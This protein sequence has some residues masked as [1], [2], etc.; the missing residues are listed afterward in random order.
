MIP[1]KNNNPI[2]KRKIIT[3][4]KSIRRFGSLLKTQ[5]YQRYTPYLPDERNP[6]VI[7]AVTHSEIKDI[8]RDRYFVAVLDSQ[9]GTHR[10]TSGGDLDRKTFVLI[11]RADQLTKDL[12]SLRFDVREYLRG[13]GGGGG[14][15]T[16]SNIFYAPIDEDK[17]SDCIV[18][19]MDSFSHGGE[20]C[21]ICNKKYSR[22]EFCVLV[23]LFFKYIHILKNNSRLSFCTY[24]KSKVFAGNPG[25]SERTFNTYAD[26]DVFKNFEER[27]KDVKVNFKN[28][29]VPS[30]VADA[31]F[32]IL[33]FQEIGYVF[34]HSPYFDELRELK[35]A[36]QTFIL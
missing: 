23:H 8:P 29:P 28:H 36:L 35:K 12:K 11:G 5:R 24:L 19:I 15:L 10:V 27:I 31:N 18:N 6:Y 22:I 34:Q 4:M 33:A 21:F 20:S 30:S 1:K 9:E 17:L 25:F 3:D 13:I 7:R 14:G 26:K 32:L 16:P 2:S